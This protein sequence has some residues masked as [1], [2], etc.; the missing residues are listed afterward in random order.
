MDPKMNNVPLLPVGA[1]CAAFAALETLRARQVDF[2]NFFAPHVTGDW[3]DL[4]GEDAARNEQALAQ[5]ARYGDNMIGATAW[6]VSAEGI[7]DYPAWRATLDAADYAP[8]PPISP[9]CLRGLPRRSCLSG[10]LL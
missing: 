2:T 4:S 8:N 10:T 7:R 9:I 5:R 3:G 1:L 6:R